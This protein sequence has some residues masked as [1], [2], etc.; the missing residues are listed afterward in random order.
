MKSGWNKLTGNEQ[1]KPARRGKKVSG[2]RTKKGAV[3]KPVAKGKKPAAK[4]KGKGKGK[5]PSK[6]EA[7]STV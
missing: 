4:G 6:K 5:R 2:K 1:K 3:K 7:Q